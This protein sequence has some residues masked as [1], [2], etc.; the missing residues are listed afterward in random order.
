MYY[1]EPKDLDGNVRIFWL[2]TYMGMSG[3]A[4]HSLFVWKCAGMFLMGK[5]SE[6]RARFGQEVHGYERIETLA[7]KGMSSD[8][9]GCT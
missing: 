2:F 6:R 7:E 5:P 9:G 4:W 1:N 8:A 3:E